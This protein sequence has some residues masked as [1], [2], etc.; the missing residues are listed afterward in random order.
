MITNAIA[1]IATLE[2]GATASA[3]Q[4][5]AT[6]PFRTLAR[7]TDSRI[8]TRRELVARTVGSWHLLWHKHSGGGDP[9]PIDV[10]RELVIAVFSGKQPA[11]YHA[12]EIVTVAREGETLVV[13]YRNQIAANSPVGATLATPF[14]IIAVRAHGTSATF[15]EDR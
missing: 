9:S 3:A 14:H 6:V 8:D 5:A 1:I 13:H 7:G 10:T 15:I 4:D 11:A 2:L 12:I